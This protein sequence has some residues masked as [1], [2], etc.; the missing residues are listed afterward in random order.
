[1]SDVQS[2]GH[3]WRFDP[4]VNLGHILTAGAFLVS[5]AAAYATLD[6]RAS[7][8]ERE[9]KAL[10]VDQKEAVISAEARLTTRINDERAR[11]DQTQVRT[12][13][14][15]REIKQIVRDGFRDLDAK[16]DRKIDKPT[17]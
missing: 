12:A 1:M 14:D 5:A 6:A 7:S 17:R 9:T 2:P 4:T 13:D 8:L 16:L 15:I 3:R 10:K 11:V